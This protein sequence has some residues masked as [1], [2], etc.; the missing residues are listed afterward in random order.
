MRICRNCKIMTGTDTSYFP[1]DG[2]VASGNTVEKRVGRS[3]V[4]AVLV[5]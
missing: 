2:I 1:Q 4:S 3:E 5:G